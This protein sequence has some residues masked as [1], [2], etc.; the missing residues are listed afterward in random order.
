MSRL[1]YPSSWTQEQIDAAELPSY[2]SNL[3]DVDVSRNEVKRY[4]Q[5]VSEC[6]RGGSYRIAASPSDSSRKKN[7]D[8]MLIHNLFDEHLQK[9]LLLSIDAE[10]FCH[11]KITEDGRRLYVF[12]V[13][14]ELYRSRVGNVLVTIYVKHDYDPSNSIKD[15]VISLHELE[16]PIQLAFVD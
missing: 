2:P 11:V 16:R 1:I 7:F 12:C 3:Y 8:F 14:R 5:E 10:E 9:E 13:K 15:I 4:L 6:I